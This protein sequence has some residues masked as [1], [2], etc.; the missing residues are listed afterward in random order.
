[1]QA[2]FIS[3]RRE[4]SEGQ[5]GRLY[6]FLAQRF[7]RDSVFMDVTGIDYGVDFSQVIEDRIAKCSVLLVVIGRR[8]ADARDAQGRRRLEIEGDFVRLE[9]A[10]ALVR[11]DV[12]VI[13]VLIGG[14]G[15]PEEKD[16]PGDLAKLA[17]LNATTVSHQHWDSDL[18]QLAARLEK[19]LRHPLWW[20]KWAGAAVLAVAVAGGSYWY[21]GQRD[22]GGG[23]AGGGGGVESKDAR[24]TEAETEARLAAL[25]KQTAADKLELIR[26]ERE[27]ADLRNKTAQGDEEAKRRESEQAASAASAA[28]AAAEQARVNAEKASAEEKAKAEAEA[29]RLAAEQKRTKDEADAKAAEAEKVRAAALA[30]SAAAAEKAEQD[31][32][33]QLELAQAAKAATAANDKLVRA[34]GKVVPVRGVTFEWR[35][36][37]NCGGR[38]EAR[39]PATFLVE[40]DGDGVFVGARLNMAGGGY[41]VQAEARQRFD[42]PQD[43]YPLVLNARWT[44][45]REFTTTQ[46]VRV[47]ASAGGTAFSKADGG[48]STTRCPGAG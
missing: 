43:V 33:A 24:L 39:G 22:A 30:A 13:P 18:R 3:Y 26:L 38:I 44:G 42:K 37:A 4:D 12:T 15:M 29:R 41:T 27:A 25:A 14:A 31:R 5:A 48:A 47:I 10:K 9:T 23:S 8:W 17:K 1:M 28:A 7:G 45:P 20:L 6:D 36:S 16:L 11:K 35:M 32:K 21:V 34:G 40:R 2:I 46:T 19:L